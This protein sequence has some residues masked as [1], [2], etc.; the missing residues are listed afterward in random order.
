M[1]DSPIFDSIDLLYKAIDE[2][3]ECNED[4]ILII[5]SLHCYINKPPIGETITQKNDRLNRTSITIRNRVQQIIDIG[6]EEA[7]QLW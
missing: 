4:V 1:F 2:H 7:Q 6:L 5:I 3:K